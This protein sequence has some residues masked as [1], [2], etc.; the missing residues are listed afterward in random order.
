M[1]RRGRPRF[2]LL[3]LNYGETYLEDRAV[4]LLP[5][6][7]LTSRTLKGRLKVATWSVSFEP[8][9]PEAPVLRVMLRE[10]ARPPGVEGDAGFALAPRTVLHK[11][12][13]H[14]P[15]TAHARPADAPPLVFRLLHAPLPPLLALTTALYEALG[16]PEAQASR[17]KYRVRKQR[18]SCSGN[19]SCNARSSLSSRLIYSAGGGETRQPR[20]RRRRSARAR[21]RPHRTRRPARGA[22]GVLL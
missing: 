18:R 2:S 19:P 16:L 14:Q 20:P 11:R 3:M 22:R 1:Q 12:E 13:A 21:L 5:A 17:L 15:F 6:P 4:S 8:D 10:C 7:P 9:D